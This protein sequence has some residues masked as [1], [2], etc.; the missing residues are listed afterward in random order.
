[1]FPD[2]CPHRNRQWVYRLKFLQWMPISEA[3]WWGGTP[4]EV[5]VREGLHPYCKGIVTQREPCRPYL[6]HD[7]HPH[8]YNYDPPSIVMRNE[9]SRYLKICP[10][11]AQPFFLLLTTVAFSMKS[12]SSYAFS[13]RNASSISVLLCK[14]SQVF[15]NLHLAKLLYGN[16]WFHAFLGKVAR[17]HVPDWRQRSY[18]NAA[19]SRRP[20]SLFFVVAPFTPTNLT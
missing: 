18:F 12:P 13:H 11:L 4:E 14:P 15:P 9:E 20:H 8:T 17:I 7:R 6:E 2:W 19:R 16:D 10:C 1:M 5:K 3:L